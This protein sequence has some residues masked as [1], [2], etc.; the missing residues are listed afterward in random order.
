[1]AYAID[2]AAV[3]A[4]HDR[5]RHLIHRTAIVTSQTVNQRTGLEVFFKPENLQKTGA[6]KIRGALNAV[7]AAFKL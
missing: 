4:A 3:K 7:S 5:I 1:M 6:F 2:L